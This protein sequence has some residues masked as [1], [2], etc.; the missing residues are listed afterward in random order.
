[1]ASRDSPRK[2]S[3]PV[4]PSM[5]H[6]K[7]EPSDHSK[8]GNYLAPAFSRSKS[9]T[10]KDIPS[11]INI[12][13]HNS[14]QRRDRLQT[15]HGKSP[16]S[17]TPD[18]SIKFDYNVFLTTWQDQI[19]MRQYAKCEKYCKEVI[20]KLMSSEQE[21]KSSY[22]SIQFVD[23]DYGQEAVNGSNDAAHSL[24]E[25]RSKVH[26]SLAYLLKKYFKRHDEAREQYE[27]SIATGL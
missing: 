24:L 18:D 1:M 12:S 21:Y 19:K 27:H 3:A 15:N 5:N 14:F 7:T 8:T 22:K 20:E 26:F 16:L 2:G 6:A 10:I 25:Y 23:A 11:K 17:P 13:S 4:L 9:A